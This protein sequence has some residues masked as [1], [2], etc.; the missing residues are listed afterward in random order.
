MQVQND[1][2]AGPW[3]VERWRAAGRGRQQRRGRLAAGRSRCSSSASSAVSS[4]RGSCHD[5]SEALSSHLDAAAQRIAAGDFSPLPIK[6]MRS[7][8]FADLQAA[9]NGMLAAVQRDAR[10]RST[11]RW[12]EE[13][14][15]RQELE[16]LQGQ[17]IRQERLAAVGQL[18]S[19]V[20][21]EINNPLQAILGFAE[22]LQMQRDVP[23]SVKG[24]SQADSEGKRA[25]LRHH[26]EP[27][28]VCTAAAR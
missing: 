8:E 22:L 6:P 23:D 17:V 4:V 19:G 14:R 21:H 3:Q 5:G 10:R 26:P 16:S 12:R 2:R 1:G 20:A 18:V 25:R 27:G 11:H 9:F 15:I 24:R 7:A 13:R 28:A